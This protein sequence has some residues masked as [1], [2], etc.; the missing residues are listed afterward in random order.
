MKTFLKWLSWLNP[1]NLFWI[2]DPCSED[3]LVSGSKCFRELA[4]E[5]RLAAIV[6]Y[7]WQG[8]ITAASVSSDL[9]T[10][11][12]SAACYAAIPPDQLN[13]IEV[14]VAA[15][16]A[17]AAGASVDITLDEVVTGITCLKNVD[18]QKLKALRIWL[19]CKINSGIS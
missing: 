14:L 12:Q 17:D 9:D 10:L 1:L 3:E 8:A 19:Q 5:D 2:V 7:L 6:W 11:L 18:P 16:E 4:P 15:E 13:A